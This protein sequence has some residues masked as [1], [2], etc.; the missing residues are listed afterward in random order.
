MRRK[1]RAIGLTVAIGASTLVGMAQ[2]AH[3]VCPTEGDLTSCTPCALAAQE[4]GDV[5]DR[6][7]I[8]KFLQENACIQ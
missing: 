8:V 6:S 4:L 1:I 5:A 2:P 7:A 3:A